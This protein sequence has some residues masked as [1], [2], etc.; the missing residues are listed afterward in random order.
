V[1]V[2]LHGGAFT[3]GSGALYDGRHLARL[4]EVV[5]VS[6]NY[7]LGVFGFADL[8]P[9]TGADVPSNLG[10]RDV[11][12]ALEWVRDNIGAFGGDPE[13]VTV[14]GES[15]GSV[16]VSLL[17][18]A[19][20]AQGLFRAAVCQSGSYSLVHGDGVRA[21]VADRYARA[22]R[23]GP[24][25]GARLWEL[26]TQA[27]SDAQRTVDAAV[28]ATTA[29]APWFDGDLL[30]ASLEQARATV[31]PQVPLLAGSNRD[32][33]KLFTALRSDILLTRREE[34]SERLHA[35]LGADS[36]R[37]VLDCYPD[38]RA[39]TSQLSTDFNFAAPTA[40]LAERHAAAGG[41]TFTY[42]FD[43]AT[44]WVGAA[45]AA[46]LVY[47]WNWSGPSAVF[48]RGPGTHAKRELA[49]RMRE[50]WVSFVRDGHPGPGWPAYTPADRCTLVLDPA[51][52]HAEPDL[53]GPR[54]HA[55]AGADV[56]PHP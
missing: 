8:G 36:A 25:G 1:L 45:H 3:S 42:R 30:P 49:G 53:F 51:G 24:G 5:V 55:W 31:R 19:P 26:P 41:T 35:A 10:L 56:T 54:R 33:I 27:F 28:H 15:A 12:A 2:W 23:V 46:E 38:T 17:L 14:A 18:C 48:L 34:L 50:H 6:V 16:L 13:K 43:A 29:A 52:D 4:G 22:L 39:G 47:L 9:A 37:A 32:E 21:E 44:P 7:R 11:L 20:A 40:H